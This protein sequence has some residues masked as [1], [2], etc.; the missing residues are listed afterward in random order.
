M[1]SIVAVKETVLGLLKGQTQIKKPVRIKG[2]VASTT[3]GYDFEFRDKHLRC[4]SVS[5]QDILE[6]CPYQGQLWVKETWRLCD[7]ESTG[8]GQYSAAIEMRADQSRP[9]RKHGGVELMDE[10]MGWRSS[11]WMPQSA[12]R[13]T[14]D[15][16]RIDIE[17]DQ[18]GNWYW[19]LDVCLAPKT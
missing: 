3:S 11:V 16:T 7:F 8:D 4:H 9:H 14:L 13:I 5:R 6:K 12:S 2:L 17:C 19:V 15:V 1:R 10:I 18:K